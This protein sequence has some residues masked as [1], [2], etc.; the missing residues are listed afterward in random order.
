MFVCAVL[1]TVVWWNIDHERTN[2]VVMFV[3]LILLSVLAGFYAA[4]GIAGSLS[5]YLGARRKR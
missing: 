2:W 4:R 5:G 3:V 1:F